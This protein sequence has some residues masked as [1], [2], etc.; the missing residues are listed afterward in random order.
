MTPGRAI[1]AHCLECV[2]G[3][4]EVRDCRGDK[5]LSGGACPFFPFRHGRGRPSVKVIRRFCLNCM[6]GRRDF[7]AEC[8]TE[9]CPLHPFRMGRNP[10]CAGKGGFVSRPFVD[11]N[12]PAGASA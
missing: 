10:A 2:G 11:E 1:R 8:E 3:P 4:H 6:N 12:R 9:G 7:V 5:L